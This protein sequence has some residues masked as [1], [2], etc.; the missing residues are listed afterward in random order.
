M[1][2]YTKA[3]SLFPSR[4]QLYLLWHAHVPQCQALLLKKI[5][6]SL[7]QSQALPRDGSMHTGK[8]HRQ[9]V[10]GGGQSRTEDC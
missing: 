3:E 10:C 7:L 2:G 8:F 6:K 5:L 1:D 9:L 4:G